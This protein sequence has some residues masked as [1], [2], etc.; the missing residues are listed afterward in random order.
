[1][2]VKGSELF[3]EFLNKLPVELHLPRYQYCGL[4]TKLAKRLTRGNPGISKLD[5]ACREHDRLYFKYHSGEN[6]KIADDILTKKF[7]EI[8]YYLTPVRERKQLLLLLVDV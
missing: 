1:M 3:N 2:Y 6:R 8:L 5:Q 7:Q 4:R